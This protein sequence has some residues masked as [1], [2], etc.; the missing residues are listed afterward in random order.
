MTD[1]E[2]REKMAEIIRK[3]EGIWNYGHTTKEI[4][5]LVKEWYK[6]AGYVRLAKDQSLPRS[7]YGEYQE[8]AAGKIFIP[9]ETKVDPDDMLKV[10][11]RK[12]E[13]GE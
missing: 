3:G 10:G 11:W 9:T 8:S 2:L 1:E 7:R 13:I 4:L 12:V 5:A 6:E